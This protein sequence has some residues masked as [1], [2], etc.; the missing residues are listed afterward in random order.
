MIEDLID[1]K[2]EKKSFNLEELLKLYKAELEIQ[3]Q[4]PRTI[5]TYTFFIKKFLEFLQKKG[6]DP[7]SLEKRH[8]KE[9]LLRT[10]AEKNYSIKSLYNLILA[11]KSFLRFLER[12]D[13]VKSLK[14]PKLPKS[15]PKA[16]TKEEIRRLIDAADNLRDKLIIILFYATGLRVSEMRNLNVED[17][18]FEDEFL[19]VRQGKG[20]KDRVVP[21]PRKVIELLKQYLKWRDEYYLNKKE[22]AL[23]LNKNGKRMSY[24]YIEKIVRN[25]GKKAG[26]KVT[27]HMLRHS[28]ATHMLENGADIR[29]IQEILGHEKL[30]TTQIYTKVTTKYLK[31]VYSKFNPIKEIKDL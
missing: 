20:R 30:S 7:Y 2:E 23:F 17:I 16:L 18:N 14:L 29:V 21:L 19:I 31:E 4:T 6:V 25:V 8:L 3:G 22:N 15:L 27:C 26:I 1:D 13:L 11:L 5:K 9:F 12:E 28:F 10:H 24:E